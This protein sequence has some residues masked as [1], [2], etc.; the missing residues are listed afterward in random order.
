MAN[1][2]DDM[3]IHCKDVSWIYLGGGGGD[4]SFCIGQGCVESEDVHW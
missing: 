2:E 1:D 3:G 4:I